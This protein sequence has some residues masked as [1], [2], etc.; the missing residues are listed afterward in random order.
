MGVVFCDCEK[1]Q[2][3]EQNSNINPIGAQK[4]ITPLSNIS[5]PQFRNSET[6][7][8]IQSDKSFTSIEENILIDKTVIIGKGEGDIKDTYEIGK[9]IGGGTYGVVFL[10][11][12]KRTDEKVAIKVMKK[13]KKNNKNYIFLHKIQIYLLYFDDLKF[14][15]FVS[16]VLFHYLIFY[17]FFSFFSLL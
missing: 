2:F 3:Q 1:K 16:L 5:T 6:I 8:S 13:K 17:Y 9:K 12:K 11:L 15:T 7:K 14:L 10:S 4:I